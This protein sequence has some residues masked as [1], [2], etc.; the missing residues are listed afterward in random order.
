MTRPEKSCTRSFSSSLPF[1]STTSVMTTPTSTLSPTSKES[2][3]LRR[4]GFSISA[5]FL[6]SCPSSVPVAGLPATQRCLLPR[7]LLAPPRDTRVVAREEDLRHAL[8]P[9]LRGPRVLGTFDRIA[10]RER[11]R[12]GGVLRAERAGQEPR[13]GVRDGHRGD[14]AAG[15]HVVADGELLGRE[16]LAD[17]FVE[18][19]VA[20]ADQHEVL[21]ARVLASDLLREGASLRSDQNGHSVSAPTLCRTHGPAHGPG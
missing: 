8:P 18:A 16:R 13:D 5:S 20:A 17:P 9:E 12:R 4:Y 15:H 3:S 1:F 6:I 2:G 19:L 11:L 14:L 21:V 10:F 7:L